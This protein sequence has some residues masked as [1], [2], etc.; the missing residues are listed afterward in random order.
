LEQLE[1]LVRDSSSDF[2]RVT[3]EKLPNKKEEEIPK[4]IVPTQED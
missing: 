4:R 3:P 1:E 2:E